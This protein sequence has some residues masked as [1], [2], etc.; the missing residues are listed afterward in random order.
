MANFM[1]GYIES[2]AVRGVQN[3]MVVTQDVPPGTPPGQGAKVTRNVDYPTYF[4]AVEKAQAANNPKVAAIRVKRP[5][6]PPD[7]GADAQ[8]NLVAL[9]KDFQID[10]PAPP[11]MAKGGVAGPPARVLRVVSPQAEF[12][13]SFH[14][15]R[16][17][18]QEPL[19]LTGRI[20][21]FDAG[22]GGK[23]YAINED[24][25]QAT[26]LNAFAARFVLVGFGTRLKG[27]PI[28]FPLS[29]AQLRGFAIQS[30]SPLDPSGWIRVNLVRTS[31]SPGAG[32]QAPPGAAPLNP[33]PGSTAGPGEGGSP[34]QPETQP[35]P[36]PSGPQPDGPA[37]RPATPVPNPAARTTAVSTPVAQG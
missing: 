19:R 18:E 13:I 4:R 10:F 9:V 26:A 23:V 24:E 33:A 11:Q 6:A 32:L 3:L 8:G 35:A 28:D 16:K 29:N 15:G 21:S 17:S 27:E 12:A 30:V 2:D 14:V 20:E 5:T 34:T 1:R 31:A 25:N 22:P 37:P 7:F 36:P